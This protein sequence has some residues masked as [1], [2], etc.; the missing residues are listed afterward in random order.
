LRGLPES[1][2]C[3]VDG[4]VDRR[5]AGGRD[6]RVQPEV[7]RMKR[8]LAVAV[9]A[10]TIVGCGSEPEDGLPEVRFGQA[11]CAHCGMLVS[12]PRFAAA[13]VAEIDG[14]RQDLAFDDIGDMVRYERTPREMKVLGR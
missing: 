5:A 4:G 2:V 9:A 10:L 8:L 13:I 11:E 1:P 7:P 14:R 3:R 12:D 6:V